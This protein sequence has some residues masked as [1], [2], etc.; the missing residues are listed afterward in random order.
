MKVVAVVPM[1]L[2]NERLPNKNI[3]KFDNGDYLCT[4]VLNNL[5]GVQNIDEVYVYCSNESIKE[6]I[7]NESIYLKRSTSLDTNTTS[8]NEVLK[9]FANTVDADIYIL[10]HATAPFISTKSISDGL[11]KVLNE[12]YDSALSVVKLQEF[13]WKD[14]VP[15]NYDLSNIPRTQD[16]APIYKETSG[17]YIFNKDTI[18]NHNRRI[19]NNPY[20]KEVSLIEAVDIDNMDDFVIANAIFNSVYNIKKI[21]GDVVE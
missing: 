2:N 8:M 4:Y 18:T 13:L 14:N 19:G 21:D 15:F 11:E 1:K 12:E 7:P 6:Y 10:C 3:K 16:L 9:S 17:F 5:L 20:L